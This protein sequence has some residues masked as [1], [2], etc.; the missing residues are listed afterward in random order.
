MNLAGASAPFIAFEPPKTLGATLL[1]TPATA[2]STTFSPSVEC[3][4]SSAGRGSRDQSA[5][6]Q[7][8]TKV[9]KNTNAR[10]R[11]SFSEVSGE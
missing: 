3:L 6:D 5:F 8:E 2:E 4:P 11:V 9:T 10:Q 7:K 1:I